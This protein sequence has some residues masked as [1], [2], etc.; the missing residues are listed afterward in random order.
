[1]SKVKGAGGKADKQASDEGDNNVED[2]NPAEMTTAEMIRQKLGNDSLTVTT[3]VSAQLKELYKANVRPV[4]AAYRYDQYCDKP[5]PD[6]E[7]DAKP[8]ILV[9]GQA[10]TGK[11]TFIRHFLGQ[12]YPGM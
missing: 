6:G 4:E 12:E 9:L 5:I 1:M 3:S 11:S 7:F 10:A 2:E 8:I